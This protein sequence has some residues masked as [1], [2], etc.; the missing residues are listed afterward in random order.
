MYAKLYPYF[1]FFTTNFMQLFLIKINF[2]KN[3]KYFLD[4]NMTDF[5]NVGEIPKNS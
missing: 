3:Q 1:F 5:S 2:K 4:L